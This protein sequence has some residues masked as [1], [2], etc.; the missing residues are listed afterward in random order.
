[1]KENGGQ[2]LSTL[3]A[4]NALISHFAAVPWYLWPS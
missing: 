4:L 2:I 1:M 3:S